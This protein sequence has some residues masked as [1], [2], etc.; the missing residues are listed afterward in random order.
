[1]ARKK[2]KSKDKIKN[3]VNENDYMGYAQVKKN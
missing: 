2:E 3:M 1:M